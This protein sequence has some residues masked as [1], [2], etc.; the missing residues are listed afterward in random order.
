MMSDIAPQEDESVLRRPGESTDV[1]VRYVF[2][3]VSVT[4]HPAR[5]IKLRQHSDTHYVRLI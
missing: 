3:K 2:F 5:S 4:Y 1:V